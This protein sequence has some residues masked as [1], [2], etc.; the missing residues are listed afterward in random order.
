MTDKELFR[1]YRAR[2]IRAMKAQDMVGER[3]F[4]KLSAMYWSRAFGYVLS[5]VE[6]RR[7]I[8][9]TRPMRGR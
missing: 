6:T 9:T 7:L 5:R 8:W 4:L 2:A 1:I 3:R